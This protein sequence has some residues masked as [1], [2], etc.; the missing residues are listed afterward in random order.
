MNERTTRGCFKTGCLGCLALV[1]LMVGL[2]IL[3]VLISLA[4]G[5]PEQH[6]ESERLR[7]TLPELAVPG[8]DDAPG[9]LPAEQPAESTSGEFVERP[10]MPEA[11]TV[12]P[13]AGHLLLDLEMGRFE[14]VP[15]PPGSDIQVEADYDSGSFELK[16]S[17]EPAADGTWT[18]Q[19]SFRDK[20]GW[21]RRFGGNNVIHNRLRLIVPQGRPFALEGKVAMGESDLEL[22]GLWLTRVDLDL[23]AGGHQLSFDE[24]L[25]H[26]LEALVIDSSYGELKARKL[27][28]ASPAL[29]KV[30]HTA[31]EVRLDLTGAW[32]QD[33]E[34][35]VSFSFGECRLTVPETVGVEVTRASINMGEKRMS[36]LDRSTPLPPGAPT[37]R[38]S[39]QGN[40]GEI[41]VLQAD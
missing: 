40:A 32:Q 24:A 15:G 3:L 6:Q 11:V 41:S 18:Y 19:L 17:Y 28:N 14:V 1:A 10:L 34:I 20:I 38:L 33:A 37:L 4:I 21:L 39:L 22:G 35:D 29:L 7:R 31:G 12:T 25:P 13:P 5:R 27:G 2:P 36:G 8:P 23:G 16:E 9:D 30:S 26:P